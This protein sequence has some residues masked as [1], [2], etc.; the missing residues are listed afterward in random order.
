M[1]KI[2]FFCLIF[3]LVH[4][5]TSA[6]VSIK[7]SAIGLTMID[8]GYKGLFPG[9][10]FADRFGYT[11]VAGVHVGYKFASNFYLTT[12]VDFLFGGK[13]KEK[14]ILNS[15][16]I[17]GYLIDNEGNYTPPRMQESGFAVPLAIGKIFGGIL[18]HNKNSG[19]Y[20]EAGAQ[21][22]QHK[23]WF[24]LPRNRIPTLTKQYQK[25]YDR[26]TNGIGATQS[27]GYRFFANNGFA[28]FVVG[29]DVSENFT[30]NRRSINLDT[31]IGDTK[32]RLDLL[33]GI[34]ACWTLPIY[35]EAASK[36]YY[37]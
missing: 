33:W 22:I 25:G 13:I 19:V 15:I 4:I 12:G 7:D 14:D 28:N 17:N 18:S 32:K 31:G 5:S 30:Q 34:R 35:K 29:L 20:V 3:L 23:I 8:V 9:G 24:N 2:Y 36:T 11:S 16:T 27:V 21:F 37:Y 10:D 6:Q 26:L 1:K